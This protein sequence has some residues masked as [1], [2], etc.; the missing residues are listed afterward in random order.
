AEM[1]KSKVNTWVSSYTSYVSDHY[2]VRTK[3]VL[4]GSTGTNE[5]DLASSLY[6]YPNPASDFVYVRNINSNTVQYMITTLAGTSILKGVVNMPQDRIDIANLQPGCYLIS[7]L[8][9]GNTPD[10][11]VIKEYP[12]GP[13]ELVRFDNGGEHVVGPLATIESRI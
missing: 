13:R 1:L 7:F 2:P 12:D 5:P 6:L 3:Y 8:T 9:E 11:A 4:T 10:T